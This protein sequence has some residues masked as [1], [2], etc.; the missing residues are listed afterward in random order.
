M[1][2]ASSKKLLKD[3]NKKS[4]AYF[5]I[6]NNMP[7]F[8]KDP[9]FLAKH[10]LAEKFIAEHGLPDSFKKKQKKLKAQSL[11]PKTNTVKK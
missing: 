5:Q 2:S 9:A 3:L 10:E 7:D 11:K 8:S 6:D 4:K 1:A